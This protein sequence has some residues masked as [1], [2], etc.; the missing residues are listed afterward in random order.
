MRLITGDETGLLKEVIPELCRP[1][2]E[3]GGPGAG[4]G[5]HSGRARPSATS[6][7]AA[8]SSYA[9]YGKDGG[10]ATGGEAPASR[11]VRRLETGEG[12]QARE[13]GVVSVCPV[14][15]RHGDDG[16]GDDEEDQGFDFAVL[17]TNGAVETWSGSR[18]GIEGERGVTAAVYRKTGGL[19][20]GILPDYDSE[21]D[22]DDDDQN[23]DANG[24]GA[25]GARG[26]YARQPIRPIGMVSNCTAPSGGDD[27]GP[28]SRASPSCFLAACDSIGNVSLL[29]ANDLGRG[30]VR[31]Y[32]AFGIDMEAASSLPTPSSS[33]NDPNARGN[34]VLTYTKGR[35]ANTSIATCLALKGDRLAVGGRERGVRI[36]EL[37]TGKLL[38]KVSCLEH[39]P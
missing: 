3:S 35:F 18:T 8:A 33:K 34:V 36:M 14:S 31:K 2:D 30:V 29:D 13:R 25:K 6:I 26:W 32:N 24:N 22:N 12:S 10:P 1:P 20:D 21:G 23:D 17:R 5:I 27:G 16:D 38:W 7:Q 39:L 28:G 37:E 15:R 4:G 9:N 11:A 19:V